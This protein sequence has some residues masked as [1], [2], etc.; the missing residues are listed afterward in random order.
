[1][2]TED[3]WKALQRIADYCAHRWRGAYILDREQRRDVALD[4]IVEALA[5]GEDDD[6]GFIR[7][8]A[9]AIHRALNEHVKHNRHQAYWAAPPSARDAVAEAVTDRIGVTQLCWIF[10]DQEWEAVSAVAAAAGTGLGQRS[11]AENAGMSVFA[12]NNALYS[13][14]SR[15]RQLWVAPGDHPRGHY[16]PGH[17]RIADNNRARRKRERRAQEAAG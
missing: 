6:Y 9:S 10:T 1:M 14:R 13:A 3:R 17:S 11:V 4:A 16:M 2:L 7:A 15:G 8:G 5:A 12:L